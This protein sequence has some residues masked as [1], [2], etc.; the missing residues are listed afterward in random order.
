MTGD[1]GR[2]N[3]NSWKIFAPLCQT[4]ND[5]LVAKQDT[6]V[7]ASPILT[8]TSVITQVVKF[9]SFENLFLLLLMLLFLMISLLPFC[10]YFL[11]LFILF[12]SVVYLIHGLVFCLFF[13]F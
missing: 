9:S 12:F 6:S 11:L 4:A 1:P 10:Y 7:S 8:G 5:H 2:S 3:W 13:T